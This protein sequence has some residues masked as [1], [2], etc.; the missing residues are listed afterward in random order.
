M[1]LPPNTPV[2]TGDT[3]KEDDTGLLFR[4]LCSCPSSRPIQHTA[5][6]IKTHPEKYSLPNAH[7]APNHQPG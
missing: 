4:V 2:K 5:Q 7:T 1:P 3:L 6:Y